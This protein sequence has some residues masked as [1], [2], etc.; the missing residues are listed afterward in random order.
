MEMGIVDTDYFRTLGLPVLHGRNFNA[1]DKQ[2]AGGKLIIDERMAKAIW[3]NEDPIGKIVFKGRAANRTPEDWRGNEVI[4]VVPTIALYG[5][6]ETSSNY[7][8]GYL[9]QSQAASNE[10]NFVLRTSVAP[11]SLEKSVREVIAAVDRDV[12]IF[13]VETMEHMIAS[14]YTT[15]TMYSWLVGFFAAVA[16]LLA[17]LG[18][19]GVIAHA[20]AARRRELGIRMAL[21]ALQRQLVALALR[22]GITPLLC[23]LGLGLTSAIVVGRLISGLLYHV[24]PY[25]SVTLSGT[26]A[27]LLGLGLLTLWL[28]ARRAAKINPMVALRE[29]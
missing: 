4:G 23:G 3:P 26:M 5:T 29:E 28:P 7:Y 13:G 9:A 20:M 11:L 12:P 15:Q 17:C 2:E 22:Q 18:L 21:G 8:Q 19:H 1:G 16:L 25:D 14:S 27:I 10:L 6:D 24:S